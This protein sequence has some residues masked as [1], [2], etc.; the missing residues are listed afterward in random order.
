MASETPFPHMMKRDVPL[1]C[2]WVI[3]PDAT[4]YDR[5]QFD[6]KVG[7]AIMPP[8]VWSEAQIKG[9]ND[10][11]RLRI[12]VVAWDH[13]LPTIIEVKPFAQLSAIGQVVSYH[14]YYKKEYGI[15]ARKLIVTNYME[16]QYV[17]A[18]YAFQINVAKVEDA[19]W[20]EIIEAC[21]KVRRD[22]SQLIRIPDGPYDDEL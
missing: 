7:Y 15:D 13:G 21:H 11:N 6:V 8:G 16:P 1:F 3:G 19:S 4:L 10:R 9:F 14:Y 22:C 17:E 5:W 20:E 2:K 12:D 18:A